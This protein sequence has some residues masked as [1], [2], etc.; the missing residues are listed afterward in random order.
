MRLY[1]KRKGPLYI[2]SVTFVLATLLL[3]SSSLSLVVSA[4]QTGENSSVVIGQTSFFGFGEN[5]GG[6][7]LGSRQCRG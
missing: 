6:P 1:I 5:N 3:G 7:A 4:F 2:L